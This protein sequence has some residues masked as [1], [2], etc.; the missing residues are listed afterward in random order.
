M[1][2]RGPNNVQLGRTVQTDPTF[3]CCASAITEQKKCCELL[4]NNVAS[5]FTGLKNCAT[6]KTSASLLWYSEKVTND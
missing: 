6:F 4:A 3:F 2:V 5:V 1:R